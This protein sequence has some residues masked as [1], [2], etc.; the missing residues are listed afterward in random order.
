[1]SIILN[2]KVDCYDT[3]TQE[4]LKKYHRIAVISIYN[5]MEIKKNYIPKYTA[6]RNVSV[7]LGFTLDIEKRIARKD[8]EG[9]QWFIQFL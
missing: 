5:Y 3:F 6:T 1:M 2:H 8:E 9:A 7:K 4:I